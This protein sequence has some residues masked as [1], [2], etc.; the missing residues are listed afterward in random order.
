MFNDSSHMLQAAAEGQGVAL[1]RES[2]LGNDLATGALMRLFDVAV[3]TEDAVYLVYPPRLAS[4]A[5]LALFR[6]WLVRQLAEDE[7]LAH[8]RHASLRAPSQARARSP[9]TRAG[10]RA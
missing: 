1:A 10:K 9:K 8:C 2:L 7:T 4:S 5:R 3:P 6:R